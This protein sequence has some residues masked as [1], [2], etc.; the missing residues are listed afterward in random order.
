MIGAVARV[1]P[2]PVG[3]ERHA[4]GDEAEKA[5]QRAERLRER[6]ISVHR[7]A[8][9]IVPRHIVRAVGGARARRLLIISL[10]V[11]ARVPR[12]AHIHALCHDEQSVRLASALTLTV[13]T[14][15]TV[16]PGKREGRAE[17]RRAAADDDGPHAE[18]APRESIDS[19]FHIVHRSW[20][21]SARVRASE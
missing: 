20:Q 4:E 3:R 15:L 1:L 7:A 19:C 2:V 14:V 21:R 16:R 12:G 18:H 11:R 9:E 10:F 6:E 5:L 13:L 17:P 8:R